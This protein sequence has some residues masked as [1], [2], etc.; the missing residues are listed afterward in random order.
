MRLIT[1]AKTKDLP[2]HQY[3]DKETLKWIIM[4]NPFEDITFSYHELSK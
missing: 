4:N 3:M 2:S 1:L